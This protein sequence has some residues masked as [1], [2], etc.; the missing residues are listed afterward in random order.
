M[1]DTTVFAAPKYVWLFRC[2]SRIAVHA[3]TLDRSAGNLPSNVCRDGKWD[4]VG[5]LVIGPDTKN[6]YGIDLEA[7]KIGI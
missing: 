2:S 6:S 5:Q 4:S 1:N 3:A 7:L